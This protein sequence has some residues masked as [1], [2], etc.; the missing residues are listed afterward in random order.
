MREI[1]TLA[2]GSCSRRNYTTTKNKR[3]TTEKLEFKKYCR[4]CRKHTVHK[5]IK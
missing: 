1:V 5:E 3:K 4:F 2:C